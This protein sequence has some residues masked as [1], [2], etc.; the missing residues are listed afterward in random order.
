MLGLH[1]NSSITYRTEMTPLPPSLF[2]ALLFGRQD[3]AVIENMR[4]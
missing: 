3:A 1:P 2:T 4:W